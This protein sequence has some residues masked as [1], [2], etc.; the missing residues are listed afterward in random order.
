MAKITSK[1][2][3]VRA[4]GHKFDPKSTPRM[5]NC[6]DCWTAYFMTAVDTAAVH[7]DMMKGG[8]RHLESVYGKTFTKE[9]GKF[10]QAQFMQEI[11]DEKSQMQGEN[12]NNNQPTG[13]DGHSSHQH[14]HSDCCSTGVCG[15]IPSGE[16]SSLPSE[17]A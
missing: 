4:C 6:E 5:K 8:K 15:E 3:T 13:S 12:E 10:L 7:D 2:G 11:N 1:H 16:I 14:A 9:F 17:G